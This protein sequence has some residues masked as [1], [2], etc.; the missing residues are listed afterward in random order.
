MIKKMKHSDTQSKQRRATR[1]SGKLN[2]KQR[3]RTGLCVRVRVCVCGEELLKRLVHEQAHHNNTSV[4]KSSEK[5]NTHIAA[6]KT[7]SKRERWRVRDVA[8]LPSGAARTRGCGNM[9]HRCIQT[10]GSTAR[11]QMP[12]H[13][14]A[15]SRPHG[16][17]RK[18]TIMGHTRERK[19]RVHSQRK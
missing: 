7:L 3:A 6:G 4:K 14:Q 15:A 19:D 5:R 13:M 17:V 11:H 16:R 2:R 12:A 1:M 8:L 10:A 9:P 18:D